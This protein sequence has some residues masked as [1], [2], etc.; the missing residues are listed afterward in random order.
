MMRFSRRGIAG[1]HRRIAMTL[2][3]LRFQRLVIAAMA[4][5]FQL[6]VH[7]FQIVAVDS[8]FWPIFAVATCRYKT[9]SRSAMATSDHSCA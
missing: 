5:A 6:I 8:I 7:C 3:A 1:K 2:A 4:A 9:A